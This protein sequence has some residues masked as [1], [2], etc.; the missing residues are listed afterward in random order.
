MKRLINSIIEKGNNFFLH[1]KNHHKV[2]RQTARKYLIFLWQIKGLYPYDKKSSHKSKRKK[3]HQIGQRKYRN[4][5]LALKTYEKML[6]LIYM[7]RNANIWYHFFL[8][9]EICKDI[10]VWLQTHRE[11]GRRGTNVLLHH[12]RK[13]N[14]C[15]KEGNLSKL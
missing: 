4:R 13:C 8:T 2:K 10:N 15:S 5:K 14:W 11:D 1:N 3:P 7:K 9:Y 6:N 12:Q